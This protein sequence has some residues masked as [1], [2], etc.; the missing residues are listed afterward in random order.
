MAFVH[1][2][3]RLIAARLFCVVLLLA[4]AAAC[5]SDPKRPPVG[6]EEPDKFLWERGT[7]SLNKKKWLVAREFFRQLIDSYPQSPYRADAKLGVG[8]SF[9]G[10]GSVEGQVLAINEFREFLSFYPTHARAD[11]AQFK[12]GMA[13]FYHMRAASRDQTETRETITEL[14]AFVQRF[15]TSPLF[16]EASARLREARDRL[17]D[18]EYGVGIHYLRT[19]TSVVGAIDRFNSILK[20]DPQY[21]R[22]DA[23]YYQMA[24]ALVLLQQP[25]AAIP[26][27]EKL[28]AEFEQSEYLEK[29][30]V[31][32]AEL[33]ASLQ[34]EVKKTST[35]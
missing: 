34:A 11:Y 24:Q 6:A 29:A 3:A 15:P 30:K 25:A 19:R 18:Y 2:G 35:P 16:P 8:D 32:A 21:T 9:L 28:L 22:R 1:T 33:K 4:A 5:G 12:L 10:E 7:D 13:H 20:G 17:S 23:V 14:T 27:L 31:Q 26:Y